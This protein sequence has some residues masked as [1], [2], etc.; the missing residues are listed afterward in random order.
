MTLNKLR[1]PLLIYKG[2]I[3]QD[4]QSGLRRHKRVWEEFYSSVTALEVF[5]LWN[6]VK[7]RATVI[8][9]SKI[10]IMSQE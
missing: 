2:K 3:L 5:C 7:S 8:V 9:N 4:Y 6:V 10:P 1:V